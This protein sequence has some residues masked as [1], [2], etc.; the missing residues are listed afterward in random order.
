[1]RHSSI[2]PLVRLIC[3][4]ML[5]LGVCTPAFAHSLK[6]F[7]TVE[8]DVVRG[9]GFFVGGGRPRGVDWTAKMDGKGVASGKTDDEG[10]FR[11][12]V[13]ATIS[14]PLTVKINSG[15]GHVASKTLAADRFG[16]AL[17]PNH[18]P[19]TAKDATAGP[20]AGKSAPKTIVTGLTEAQLRSVVAHEITPLLERIEEM[21]ARV[22][23]AD[24][25]A[26]IC[27]IFGLAGITM[28]AKTR[29]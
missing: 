15:D 7:A 25:I 21:D 18:Q 17:T 10:A 27:L 28:W 29:R 20:V 8:G 22:R 26:G 2:L 1:M 11:F 16:T 6:L 4:S 12:P 9:Y 13:P 23:L 24:V 19:K 3:L 14:G 5:C